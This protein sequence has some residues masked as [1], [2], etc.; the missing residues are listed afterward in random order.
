MEL[1]VILVGAL[2]GQHRTFKE[3]CT[4]KKVGNG[5]HLRGMVFDKNRSGEGEVIK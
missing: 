2:S 1:S 3:M 5:L 4:K